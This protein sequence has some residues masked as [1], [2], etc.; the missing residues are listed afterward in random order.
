MRY[1]DARNRDIDD[2]DPLEP[3]HQVP[4][5]AGAS[6]IVIIASD[7][8]TARTYTLSVTREE[9]ALSAL[10]L[11][12]AAGDPVEF[13]PGFAPEEPSYWAFVPN[14][15]EE[16]TIDAPANSD[17]ANFRYRKKFGSG[18]Y[19]VID[20][21]DTNKDGY[22]VAL[23]AGQTVIE[24][25]V[26]HGGA[27]KDYYLT[28]TRAAAGDPL[29]AELAHAEQLNDRGGYPRWH[30]DLLLSESVWMPE[31][32][33]REH[34]FEVFNGQIERVSRVTSETETVGGVQREVSAHWR[35]TVVPDFLLETTS[36]SITGG[37]ACD[38]AGA[39]C[40]P[41]GKQLENASPQSNYLLVFP[42][43]LDTELA[44]SKLRVRD[45]NV[46]ENRGF[47]SVEVELR[48]EDGNLTTVPSA[49]LRLRMRT[50]G[51]TATAYPGY[52][53]NAHATPPD[54]PVYPDYWAA[55]RTVVIPPDFS[56]WEVD[57]V[58]LIPDELADNNETV[59]VELSDASVIS[60]P[61]GL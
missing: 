4:L 20:D 43:W 23:S 47:L 57:L 21:E 56:T 42:A 48:D 10:A 5:A 3:G 19:T 50:V 34:V 18:S 16:I 39:L 25:R 52:P 36:V 27:T 15:V 61:L 60:G 28:V 11:S 30:F 7:A 6:T 55:D 8:H 13:A 31:D 24:I 14:A 35:L 26:T 1:R 44:V 49:E 38:E 33:M 2:A 54:P 46:P 29:T 59:F 40:T 17:A 51:G 9:P 32:A 53:G 41:D 22:Q 12:D 37:R 45:V 58:R